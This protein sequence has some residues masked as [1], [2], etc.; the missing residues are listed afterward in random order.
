MVINGETCL[1]VA[2]T[3]LL[4]GD[5]PALKGMCGY[6]PS[7]SKTCYVR[8]PCR[9]C[10][11]LVDDLYD[12][13]VTEQRRGSIRTVDA[14][15]NFY[16]SN[17]YKTGRPDVAWLREALKQYGFVRITEFIKLHG[18]PA[19]ERMGIDTMHSLF[20]G[21]LVKLFRLLVRTL[22]TGIGS[23]ATKATVWVL[24]SKEFSNYCRMNKI[25]ACWRFS[26]EKEF[27]K[28]MTAGSMREFTR[29][30]VHIIRKLG[31]IRNRAVSSAIATTNSWKKHVR[32]FNHWC[33]QVRIAE[34]VGQ[35]VITASDLDTLQ[36]LIGK[37]LRFIHDDLHPKFATIN[38]HYYLHFV[39]QIRWLGPM[40]LFANNSREHLIQNIKPLYCNTNHRHTEISIYRKY[41]ITLFLKVMDYI[42]NN[43]DW[44]QSR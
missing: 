42:T 44:S 6:S 8:M 31:L 27:K 19:P 9:I 24:I 34:I 5:T 18:Q 29:V 21:V 1:V 11:V 17:C 36:V 32:F 38:V 12:A 16:R 20:L 13:M 15:T 25:S 3:L 35:H 39:D 10:E 14:L 37:L 23:T 40:R 2:F 33:V 30:S 26:N 28:R 7:I 4:M 43:L 22:T 41:R